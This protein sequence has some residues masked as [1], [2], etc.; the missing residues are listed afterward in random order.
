VQSHGTSGGGDVLGA[1]REIDPPVAPAELSNCCRAG[2][3]DGSGKLR[4]RRSIGYFLNNKRLFSMSVCYPP[5]RPRQR[6][7]D[8]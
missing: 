5:A 3:G 1:G 4:R 6:G 7:K 2:P 8:G